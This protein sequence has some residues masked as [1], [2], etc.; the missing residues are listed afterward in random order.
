MGD[1]EVKVRQLEWDYDCLD[2]SIWNKDRTEMKSVPSSK[3]WNASPAHMALDYG[4]I[5]IV[6]PRA[7]ARPGLTLTIGNQDTQHPNLESAKGAA[8]ADYDQR[9]MSALVIKKKES[10]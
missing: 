1:L 10:E 6:D 2:V 7:N 9:V 5:Q 3:H 8:Q 4:I